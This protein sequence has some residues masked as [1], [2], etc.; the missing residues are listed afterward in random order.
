[1]SVRSS[2][3]AVACNLARGILEEPRWNNLLARMPKARPA[4]SLATCWLLNQLR[5]FWGNFLSR[6]NIKVRWHAK[7][8]AWMSCS[9]SVITWRK[10]KGT[11]QAV[12]DSYAS[13]CFDLELWPF[14]LKTNYIYSLTK[15][16][17]VIDKNTQVAQLRRD[18]L[19]ILIGWVTLRQNFRSKGCV[20]HQ[21]L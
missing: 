10:Q 19:V 9:F 6:S 3:L 20:L 5:A 2:A 4:V 12:V 15:V 14:D 1:M 11:W 17:T 8:H 18:K 7:F 21:Y 13:A 16:I